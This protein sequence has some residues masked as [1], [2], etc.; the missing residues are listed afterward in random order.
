MRHLLLAMLAPGS[1]EA[2]I[3]RVQ[4]HIFADH[5]LVSAVA[6]PPLVPVA[7]LAELERVSRRGLLLELNASVVSPYRIAL[8]GLCW[9]EG[10][11]YF[12]F[13][14]GG[15][16]ESLRAAAPPATQGLFPA[17]EGFFLGCGESKPEHR[18]MIR[19]PLPAI[20]FTSSSLALIEITTARLDGAWWRE[21]STETLEE[22]P[23]RGR[24]RT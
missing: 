2:E 1:A 14:S 16:W 7:F 8:T 13:H 4:Q 21:V 6:L 15:V 23:L 20:G 12:A 24:R 18:E 3:G 9:R 17:F 5:G 19:P 10:W 11:L 22:I